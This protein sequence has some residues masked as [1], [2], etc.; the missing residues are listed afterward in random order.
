MT[1]TTKILVYLF[2]IFLLGL[3]LSS[4]LGS[5]NQSEVINTGL[6]NATVKSFSFEDNTDVCTGLANVSFTIDHFGV[7]DP[8]LAGTYANAGII[9]NPDSLPV[10]TK[11][12]S[13]KV[14][15]DTGN[16]T[17]IYFRQFDDAGNLKNTVNFADTQYIFFNDYAVTRLDITSYDGNF[18]K[19]YFVK[20]N[21]HKTY[22]DT[23]RWKYVAQN[24]IDAN[25]LT[26][27]K[28]CEIG[29]KLFWFAEYGESS[30]KLC[31]SSFEN[32]TTWSAQTEIQ[33]EEKPVL[34]TIYTWKNA[35]VAVG[36]NGT[37]LS[38]GDG[39]VWKTIASEVE[40]VN[41]IGTQ[42]KAK[43]NNQ[44]LHAIVKEN[45]VYKFATSE[46]L[47]E[48]K[49]LDEIPENFP[50]KNFSN[51]ILNEP[52]PSAGNVTSRITIVGGETAKGQ[53]ISSA[54]SCDG[55]NWAEFEQNYLPAMTS[56]AIIEY[57][58][59]TDY[60][61][62][63]LILWPGVLADGSVRNTPYFSENKGVT[64][65]LLSKEFDFAATTTTISPVGGVS[66][67][68]NPKNYWMYFFGGV[69]ENGQPQT[70]IFGGQLSKLAFD[71]RR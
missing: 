64:W 34:S 35:F 66:C 58:L 7:S 47:S 67:A 50:I 46:N 43:N 68:M 5:G 71:K 23:I 54:W 19:S 24:A 10:G 39:V 31:T 37:M 42:L 57:T 30:T 2:C 41:I 70:N 36:K 26:Q 25:A 1:S 8:E 59:D 22:G 38:S 21:V 44:F 14:S 45:G 51:A 52:K 56:P 9:F 27:Q 13:I 6:Q 60:P 17:S 18:K 3:S 69:D 53:S 4:C 20:V 49:V 65:K 16:A 28:V 40:F 55:T 32:P 29:G 33:A 15:L 62:S 11:P 63:F 61:K 48:W 12:D